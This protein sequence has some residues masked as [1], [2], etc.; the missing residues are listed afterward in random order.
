MRLGLF[1]PF[2][3]GL[4]GLALSGCGAKGPL[5]LPP[6]DVQTMHKSSNAGKAPPAETP[7]EP[8]TEPASAPASQ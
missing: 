7:A 1:V 6:R 4:V 5:I 2:A 3:F 8:T